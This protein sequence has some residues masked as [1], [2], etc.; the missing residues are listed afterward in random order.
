[1]ARSNKQSRPSAAGRRFKHHEI[2]LPD[3]GKLVLGEDGVIVEAGSDG[4]AVRS[5]PMSDPEWAR[6]A[7]RFGVQPPSETTAPDRIR[8][9][10]TR[11]RL[12]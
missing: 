5:W 9:D 7:I 11:L 12:R 3:G 2:E 6:I 1:V 4:T 10:D 8:P